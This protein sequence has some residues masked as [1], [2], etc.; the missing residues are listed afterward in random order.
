MKQLYVSIFQKYAIINNSVKKRS[1]NFLTDILVFSVI[2]I[3]QCNYPLYIIIVF[4]F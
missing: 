4:N 2:G 1:M 3:R